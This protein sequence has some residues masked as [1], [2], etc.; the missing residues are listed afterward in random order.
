MVEKISPV[1]EFYLN[2]EKYEQDFDDYMNN[3]SKRGRKRKNK[4]YFTPV[5]EKAIVAYN[6]EKTYSKR[7]R[8]YSQ[9]IHYPVWKLAQNIINRFKFPYMNGTTEDKQYEV[10]GFLLQKL[11]KYT[12]DKGRAFS[13]FSIVA[14]NYCIQTNNKAYKLLKSK[15]DLLAVDKARDT[16]NEEHDSSR[17]ESLK[18]FTDLFVEDYDSRVETIFSKNSDIK[19]AYAV[20]ELFRRRENIEK[21]NKKAL[22]VLI[23]EMTDE[24][25]QDISR[26]VNLIKKDFKEKFNTYESIAH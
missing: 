10:I 11:P 1:D 5:T 8:V 3:K 24:K 18:D 19:I 25:T 7:N 12:E 21:Y 6:S 2:V 9:H 23:R 15:T 22:Y 4:M 16:V 20:M 14:K 13:Y 26:V 17:K